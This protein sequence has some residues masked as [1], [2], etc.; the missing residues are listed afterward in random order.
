MV[1]EDLFDMHVPPWLL[2][3]LTSY[4][5]ERSMVMFYDGATSS[6]RSLPGSS[7]QGAFL[8]I[9]FFIIKYNAASLRPKISKPLTGNMCRFKRRN[10]RSFSCMKHAKDMHALYIDDLTEAEGVDLKKEVIDDPVQRPFPLN[11]HER[12]QHIFPTENSLLQKQLIKV[13]QFTIENKMKINESK[14]Q[15]MIFNKSRKYDFPP[16][17]SFANNVILEVVEKTRLIGI[18]LT[19]DLRW[20]ANTLYVLKLLPKCGYYEG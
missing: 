5:T 3:I 10:C 4:L 16:E 19:S 18:I 2:L 11:F 12:T 15:I 6:P 13:E 1:I 7:P 8:G 20:E 9:F 14:S 17:Y